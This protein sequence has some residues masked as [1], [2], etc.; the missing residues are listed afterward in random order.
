MISTGK[1]TANYGGKLKKVVVMILKKKSK[2]SQP[3]C[4]NAGTR[5]TQMTLL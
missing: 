5:L 3:C 1:A 4:I 2:H